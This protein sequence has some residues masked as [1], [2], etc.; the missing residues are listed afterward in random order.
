ML[1]VAQEN[2]RALGLPNVELVAGAVS[3]LPLEN[4]SVDAAFANIVLF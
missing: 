4:G 3:R 1:G 2:L